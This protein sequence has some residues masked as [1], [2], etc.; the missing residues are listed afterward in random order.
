MEE[1]HEMAVRRVGAEVLGEQDVNG[2]FKHEGVING[3]HAHLGE[4]VPARA[5]AA[6]D[7]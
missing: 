7:G 5:S 4:A 1:L 6:G 2:R 3:D